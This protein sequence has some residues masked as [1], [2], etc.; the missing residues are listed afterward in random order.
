MIEHTLRPTGIL[1]F[2]DF[3]LGNVLPPPF[4]VDLLREMWDGLVSSLK[5]WWAD[6]NTS[7]RDR[8][9]LPETAVR[10][11]SQKGKTILS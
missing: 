10:M 1:H 8:P 7:N 2:S 11:V 5:A 3:D 6:P 4:S 9:T